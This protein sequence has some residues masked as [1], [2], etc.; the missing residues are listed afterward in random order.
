MGNRT[1]VRLLIYNG[2]SE[3]VAATLKRSIQGVIAIDGKAGYKTIR[4]WTLTDSEGEASTGNSDNFKG[5]D[6]EVEE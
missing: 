5:A 6:A 3:W 4:A 2:P 1:V